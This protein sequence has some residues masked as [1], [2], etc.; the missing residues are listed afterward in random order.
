MDEDPELAM[1]IAMS[2]QEANTASQF[3]AAA[4]AAGA[5][6]FGLTGSFASASQLEVGLPRTRARERKK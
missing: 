5:R 2:L 3:D 6:A 4:L 1:A